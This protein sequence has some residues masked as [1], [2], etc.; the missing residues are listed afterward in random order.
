MPLSGLG[1]N[2]ILGIMTDAQ[3]MIGADGRTWK[4]KNDAG[5]MPSQFLGIDP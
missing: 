1:A 3:A 5:S 2:E 4:K